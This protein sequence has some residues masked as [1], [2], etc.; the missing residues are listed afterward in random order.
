MLWKEAEIPVINLTLYKQEDGT[1]KSTRDQI[2]KSIH[3]F[4]ARKD[5]CHP[6]QKFKR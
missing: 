3:N 4:R 1:I 2:I 6:N 5:S